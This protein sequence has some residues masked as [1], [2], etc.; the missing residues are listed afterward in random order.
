MEMTK[1]RIHDSMTVGLRFVSLFSI[2]T[3]QHLQT[4][5]FYF[6]DLC[7]NSPINPEDTTLGLWTRYSSAKIQCK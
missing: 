6:V 3:E 7:L 4:Y 5:T 1:I 2:E